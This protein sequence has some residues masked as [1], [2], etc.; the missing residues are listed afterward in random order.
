MRMTDAGIINTLKQLGIKQSELARQFNVTPR[1]V[2]QWTSGQCRLP[3]RVTTFLQNLIAKDAARRVKEATLSEPEPKTLDD[4]I[5]SLT[6]VADDG[7]QPNVA[8]G[9]AV[10]RNGKILGSD[11]LGSVFTGRYRFD[12]RDQ[13]NTIH[14]R[15]KVPDGGVLVTGLAAGSEGLSL[16]IVGAFDRA[17]PASKATVDVRGTPVDVYLTL[18][19]DLPH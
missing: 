16:D 3:K 9:L 10:F 18:L 6:Y 7:N 5:Y 19:G 17:A 11:H 4:G 1:T 8:D 14:V 12:E 13:T 15:L 2:G